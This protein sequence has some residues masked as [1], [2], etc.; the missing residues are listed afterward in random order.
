MCEESLMRRRLVMTAQAPQERKRRPF[1][2]LF[3]SARPRLNL[4]PRVRRLIEQVEAYSAAD[5]PVAEF[6]A[7]AVHLRGC[8]LCGI[9]DEGLPA[10]DV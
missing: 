4:T 7:P 5:G 3:P 1:A 2:E 10:A 6:T 8:D 9:V